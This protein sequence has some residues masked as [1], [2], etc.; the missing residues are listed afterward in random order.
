MT[1]S[2]ET[3]AFLHAHGLAVEPKE[4]A[5]GLQVALEAIQ[6]LYYPPAGQEGL[7]AEEVEV[8]RSG[9][10]EPQPIEGGG[11]D[12][13][14]SGVV[15]FAGLITSGLTTLQAAA[16]L[17]VSDAR[18]RQ[19]LH[20]RTLLGIQAR[21]VWKLP[22]FQFTEQGELPGWTEVCPYLPWTVSPVAVER[23]L[24]LAHPDL[25]TGADEAP[26]S[27]RQWLLSGRPP[28]DVAALAAE[29]A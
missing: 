15:A 21:H 6:A 1:C 8:A 26:V 13:L 29:L 12:P 3:R 11:P 22:V 10:L 25:V 28:Q 5:A 7:T 9:G 19:R 4:L 16:R 17:G 14:L 2:P 23:W 27:P 18:I 20:G 24:V